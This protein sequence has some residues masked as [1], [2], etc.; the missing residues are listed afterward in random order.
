VPPK[1]TI[2]MC[3]YD[4][5]Y[6]TYMTIQSII[7]HHREV[8]DDIQFVVVDNNPESAHGKETQSYISGSI[9]NG[10][11]IPFTEYSSTAT[12]NLVFDNADAPFVLCTDCH[13]M[14]PPN[15]FKRLIDFYD[16]N[17]DSEDLYHGP[18]MWEQLLGKYT[19]PNGRQIDNLSTHMDFSSWRGGMW[20]TWAT[21]PEGRGANVDDTPFEIQGHGMGMFSTKR[22]TW[23]RFSDHFRQFGGEE[24]YI[25]EK[26]RQAGRKVYCLPFLRWM[27]RFYRPGGAPYPLTNKA[28]IRNYIVG[29]MELNM[30]IDPI[31]NHFAFGSDSP[32]D[33]GIDWIRRTVMMI[34]KDTGL[35]PIVNSAIF[36][37]KLEINELVSS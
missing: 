18:M 14:F 12:R 30:A 20:G 19:L 26:Y 23:L 9:P 25:H 1:L 8:I 33:I 7:L 15:T 13:C 32:S 17:P 22:D 28:K 35:I 3:T 29:H 4:D 16:E 31:I 27:H 6:G 36:R 11:Y 5:F 34:N 2:G 10:K 37:N 21:D 24:G